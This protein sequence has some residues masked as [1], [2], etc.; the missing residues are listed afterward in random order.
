MRETINSKES[1][2]TVKSLIDKM[3]SE[4]GYLEITIEPRKKTRSGTQNRALHLYLTQLAEALNDAGYDMK[5]TIKKEVDIPWSLASAKEY[6]WGPV[7][8][9]VTGLDRTS[10]ADSKQYSEI[11]EVLNR[12]MAQKFGILVPWPKK[13]AR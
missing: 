3:Q 9:A 4:F 7:Q 5:R 13:N 11:Y 2:D 10:K 12:H 6:L 8:K 1:L